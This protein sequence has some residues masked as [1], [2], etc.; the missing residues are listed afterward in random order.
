MAGAGAGA[1]AIKSNF[2]RSRTNH[3]YIN[4][5]TLSVPTLAGDHRDLINGSG[6]FKF[7]KL[8]TYLELREA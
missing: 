8:T 7:N 2:A 1:G 6:N 3:F 5:L 4:R